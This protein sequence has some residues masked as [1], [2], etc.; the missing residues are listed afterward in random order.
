MK[1]S[2]CFIVF[3]FSFNLIFAQ[4]EIVYAQSRVERDISELLNQYIEAINNGNYLMNLASIGFYRFNDDLIKKSKDKKGQVYFSRYLYKSVLEEEWSVWRPTYCCD[5]S[6]FAKREI[7]AFEQGERKY[8]KYLSFTAF[9]DSCN[10][11]NK[12][13]LKLHLIG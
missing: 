2:I 12:S 5:L 7:V 13:L 1:K 4:P 3:I 8:P 11:E 9:I 6:S 10:R